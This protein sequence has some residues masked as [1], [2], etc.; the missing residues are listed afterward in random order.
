[1]CLRMS[2]MHIALLL[3]K[4]PA[5]IQQAG[6][7][8]EHW[9]QSWSHKQYEQFRQ[10]CNFSVRHSSQPDAGKQPIE[11]SISISVQ[12]YGHDT[13]HSM[14]DVCQIARPFKLCN[15]CTKGIATRSM[16]GF[17]LPGTAGA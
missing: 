15:D 17:L 13:L 14:L 6:P 10:M 12:R 4:V 3:V 16:R 11:A 5:K 7:G 1:M 8:A 2:E 9:Y